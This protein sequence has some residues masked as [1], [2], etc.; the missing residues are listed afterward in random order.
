MDMGVDRDTGVG[1]GF[2]L[3][4]KPAILAFAGAF[5]GLRDGV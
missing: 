2:G 3:D 5:R 1:G 4:L